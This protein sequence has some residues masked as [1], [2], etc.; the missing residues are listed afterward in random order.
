MPGDR[1]DRP[2]NSQGVNHMRSLNKYLLLSIGLLA[3]STALQAKNKKVKTPPKE[4][5][6][7]IEVVGHI[8]SAGGAISYFVATQHYSSYYLYAEH[9][10]GK[11]ITLIDVTNTEHP[12]VLAD[13]AYPPS[14]VATSLPAVAGT[15]A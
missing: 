14:G 10:G 8:P 4:P 5:Q 13:L 15:A 1:V 12:A 9:E 7:E 11:S 2:E 3:L 6:D